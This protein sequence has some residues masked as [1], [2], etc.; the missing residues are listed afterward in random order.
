MSI[1]SPNSSHPPHTHSPLGLYFCFANKFTC[2]IFLVNCLLLTKILNIC[3]FWAIMTALL[4]YLFLEVFKGVGSHCC[5]HVDPRD[6]QEAETD[7]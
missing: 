2:I 7:A 3:I 1:E 4:K 6:R 5:Q